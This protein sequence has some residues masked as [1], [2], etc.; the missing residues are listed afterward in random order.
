VEYCKVA[1]ENCTAFCH[2]AG[3]RLGAVLV[4]PFDSGIAPCND[5]AMPDRNLKIARLIGSTPSV[6]YCD[7]CRLVFNTR[8]EF[9]VDSNKALQQLQSDF[10]KHEC[11]PEAGAVNSALDDIR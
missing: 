6:A 1:P 9:L 7:L 5:V 4:T 8:Q 3:P 11:K 2:P 10:D